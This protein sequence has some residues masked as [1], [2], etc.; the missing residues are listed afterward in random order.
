[1]GGE[2]QTYGL[3]QSFGDTQFQVTQLLKSQGEVVWHGK[4]MVRELGSYTHRK[5]NGEID[6]WHLGSRPNQPPLKPGT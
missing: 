2:P 3:G 4:R 1:M 5:T 6:D